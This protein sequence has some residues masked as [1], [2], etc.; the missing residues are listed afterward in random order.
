[1]PMRTPS[2]RLHKPTG[3][4]VV[5]IDG[6]DHYLGKFDSAESRENYHRLIAEW[7]GSG[8]TAVS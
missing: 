2:Y 4:A 6:K 8:K 7:L 5:T 3:K 1:M